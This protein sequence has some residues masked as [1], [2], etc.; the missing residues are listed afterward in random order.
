MTVSPFV[1]DALTAAEQL[2][3]GSSSLAGCNSARAACLIARQ[4]LERLV[5]ELLEARGLAC[6]EASMRTRLI[7]LGQAWA[8]EA[9]VGYR[10]ATAWWRLSAACHHHAYELDPTLAEA[11]SAIADVRWLAKRGGREGTALA[12][13]G[14]GEGFA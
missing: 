10:A 6:P 5:D 7:A 1:I 3:A 4:A 12:G 14:P 8:D 11:A 13:Q 2:A 9:D